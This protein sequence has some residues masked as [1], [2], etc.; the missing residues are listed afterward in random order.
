MDR[1]RFC[2]RILSP[3]ATGACRPD[4]PAPSSL[5]SAST[6][7]L[8]DGDALSPPLLGVVL[9]DDVLDDLGVEDAGLVDL[10]LD[11]PL[12]AGALIWTLGF[13]SLIHH[14]RVKSKVPNK[15]SKFS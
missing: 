8:G 2:A 3:G 15:F 10:P 7:R 6:G 12:A 4:G 14:I 11:L 5:P 1:L 13:I 9:G